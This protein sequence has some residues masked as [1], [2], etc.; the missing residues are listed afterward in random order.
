MLRA[1]FYNKNFR[2]VPQLNAMLLGE[3]TVFKPHSYSMNHLQ[4]E[5]FC[6]HNKLTVV[7]T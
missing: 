5:R 6:F 7:R 2:L 3:S 1:I 4:P